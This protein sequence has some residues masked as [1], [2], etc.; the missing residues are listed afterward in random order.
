[1][2]TNNDTQTA[3]S[4][5]TAT[6]PKLEEL[7]A[8]QTN[9]NVNM[10]KQKRLKDELASLRKQLTDLEADGIQEK[11]SKFA[12]LR[13]EE[14]AL[15]SQLDKARL[16]TNETTKYR[17]V[18]KTM[19]GDKPKSEVHPDIIDA[20]N[21]AEEALKTVSNQATDLV[22]KIEEI[23]QKYPNEQKSDEYH[24]LV[25]KIKDIES[26]L[27]EEGLRES[28]SGEQPK[29]VAK[30]LTNAN[31]PEG[32]EL[33]VLPEPEP[34]KMPRIIVPKI[35]DEEV[36]QP[37]VEIHKDVSSIEIPDE[38]APIPSPELTI[39]PAI[40]EKPEV[41]PGKGESIDETG[42]DTE[43][44]VGVEDTSKLSLLQKELAKSEQY[45][46]TIDQL[47]SSK[48]HLESQVR[49]VDQRID[50]LRQQKAAAEAE[51]HEKKGFF[52]SIGGIFGGLFGS[53]TP[54]ETEFDTAISRL[55]ESK[56]GAQSRLEALSEADQALN[57]RPISAIKAEIATE[58]AAL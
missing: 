19:V 36:D 33:I 42:N 29:M 16:M 55:E 38:I 53:D 50:E 37:K 49:E 13:A 54:N 25:K 43:S 22:K 17:D 51:S 40:G 35:L 41:E 23:K 8:K 34:F 39:R 56:K 20:L 47:S 9:Y 27:A 57:S 52:E 24:E 6:L 2:D 15:I 3:I 5:P 11:V 18:V 28:E 32:E 26:Q 14:E 58:E 4:S 7:E 31:V 12:S 10:A 45:Q 21:V 48:R 46:A 30:D 44:E 1:M